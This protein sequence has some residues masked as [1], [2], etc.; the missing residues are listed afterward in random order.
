MNDKTANI[1][2]WVGRILFILFFL[3]VLSFLNSNNNCSSDF[4]SISTAHTVK[5]ENY[6][7]LERTINFSNYNNSVNPGISALNA[8]NLQIEKEN[9]NIAV[10]QQLKC[11]RLRFY[12]IKPKLHQF[13]LHHQKIFS[14]KEY[15]MI[16]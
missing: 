10:N 15:S 8:G 3:F 7:I 11:Q 9:L 4:N 1:D 2:S 12:K 13:L 14:Q 16:S 6:A 5:I